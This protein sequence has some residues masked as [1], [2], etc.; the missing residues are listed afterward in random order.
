MVPGR[1]R[2]ADE[3]SP[4]RDSQRDERD[5]RAV[6]RVSAGLRRMTPGEE[7]PHSAPSAGGFVQL[8]AASAS[9]PFRVLGDGMFLFVGRPSIR[10][11]ASPRL[12]HSAAIAE[13]ASPVLAEGICSFG[14][15]GKVLPQDRAEDAAGELEAKSSGLS[16]SQSTAPARRAE[17]PTS[18][19][20][21]Y[22]HDLRSDPSRSTVAQRSRA[23]VG[24]SVGDW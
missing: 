16:E 14:V 8:D 18:L 15:A 7:G 23:P 3:R 20:P 22:A 17:W 12:D 24:L 4:G 10:R 21:A 11:P 5:S 13:P 6:R 2:I 19:T 9:T 1:S